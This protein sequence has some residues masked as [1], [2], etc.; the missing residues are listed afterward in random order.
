MFRKITMSL[1][2]LAA[3]AAPVALAASA[4]AATEPTLSCQVIGNTTFTSGGVGVGSCGTFHPDS[5]YVIDLG[6]AN[7]FTFTSW[8]T[9]GGTSVVAGCTSGSQ[10]CDL[11]VHARPADQEFTTWVETDDSS[12]NLVWLSATASIPAVCG[13]SL[14]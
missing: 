8:A 9:P 7:G 5:S 13:K 14:C 11:L 3:L 6:L 4:S 12:G 10:F 2:G 1:V